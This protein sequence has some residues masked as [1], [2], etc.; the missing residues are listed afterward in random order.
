MEGEY[1]DTT[2]SVS[3][4]FVAFTSTG[5]SLVDF[6]DYN[7][8]ESACSVSLIAFRSDL[9]TSGDLLDSLPLVVSVLM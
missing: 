3:F 8:V 5:N 7:V 2:V 9:L 1:E 4:A 6:S